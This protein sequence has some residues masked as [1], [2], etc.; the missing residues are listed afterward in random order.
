ME[1]QKSE[2][3]EEVEQ[4]EQDV[5]AL[6]EQVIS[7]PA[8]PCLGANFPEASKFE[9]RLQPQAIAGHDEAGELLLGEGDVGGAA[10]VASP[11]GHFAPAVARFIANV[12]GREHS[13][14][15]PGH[16]RFSQRSTALDEL[17]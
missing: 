6:K 11:V 1:Q 8:S 2:F 15:P 13:G 7:T 17:E 10:R 12:G 14:Q 3:R 5:S 9:V 16:L 4:L